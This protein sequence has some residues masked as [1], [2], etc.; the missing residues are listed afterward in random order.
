M[1]GKPTGA[2]ALLAGLAEAQAR[3]LLEDAA[4]INELPR[5]DSDITLERRIRLRGVIARTALSLHKLQAQE[6]K[7]GG[8]QDQEEADMDDQP[9]DAET[10]ERKYMD[11][12]KGLDRYA[13]RDESGGGSGGGDAGRAGCRPGE[14]ADAGEQAPAAS[15]GPVAHLAAARRPG[16]GEDL[17]GRRLAG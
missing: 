6:D 2:A 7:A 11:L 13:G 9:D 14:L 15:E 4:M 8:G 1:S 17:G 5:P 12:Q 3:G 10:L 16:L